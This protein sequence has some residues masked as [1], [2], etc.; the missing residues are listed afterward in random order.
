[1]TYRV[2]WREQTRE[3]VHTLTFLT[4]EMGG[5]PDVLARAVTEIERRLGTDPLTAGE[6][7]GGEERVL[8][9]PPLAVTY[10]PFS[11]DGVVIIY[12][13]HQRVDRS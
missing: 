2:I 8:I 10:E 7:R 5:N 11:K 1:M 13:A 12:A 4:L 6:S 3:Y 9:V